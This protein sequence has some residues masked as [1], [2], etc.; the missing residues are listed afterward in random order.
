[1]NI[2]NRFRA[3]IVLVAIMGMSGCSGDSLGRNST[4]GSTAMVL[5]E[6]FDTSKDF[7]AAN[8]AMSDH[9]LGNLAT[10]YR[11]AFDENKIEAIVTSLKK[12]FSAHA[13]KKS[14]RELVALTVSTGNP[15]MDVALLKAWI[16]TLEE[17]T[18]IEKKKVEA[19]VAKLKVQAEKIKKQLELEQE[20][21]RRKMQEF[22]EKVKKSEGKLL[23]G[24]LPKP[25]QESIKKIDKLSFEYA[26]I[27]KQTAEKG[28]QPQLHSHQKKVNLLTKISPVEVTEQQKQDYRQRKK[29]CPEFPEVKFAV[30]VN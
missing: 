21:F 30:N 12:N 16:G 22:D 11:T 24:E 26:E 23:E 4:G 7:S 29:L 19:E 3:F 9:I 18:Q 17:Q 27:L 10:K 14:P 28:L 6:G 5:L 2:T 13:D 1:M 8:L 20:S 25:D 15:A